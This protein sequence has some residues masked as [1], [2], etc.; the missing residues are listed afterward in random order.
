MVQNKIVKLIS[1][2][3][4]KKEKSL[5][6]LSRKERKARALKERKEGK[7]I[8]SVKLSAFLSNS[9]YRLIQD[10]YASIVVPEGVSMQ[11]RMGSKEL[12]FSC[13]NE[14]IAEVLID[15]LDASGIPWQE[16]FESDNNVGLPDIFNK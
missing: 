11:N 3:N 1:I 12:N 2:F 7:Q 15:A 14:E 4:D 13:E 6:E 9:K 8:R 10:G 5:W 16:E